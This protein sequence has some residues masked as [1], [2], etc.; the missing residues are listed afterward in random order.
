MG[1][2]R[3]ASLP[4]VTIAAT[5]LDNGMQVGRLLQAPLELL[6]PM[7]PSVF[8]MYGGGGGSGSGGGGGGGSVISIRL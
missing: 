4:Q 1:K 5:P 2:T 8:E 7:L 3:S 6:P